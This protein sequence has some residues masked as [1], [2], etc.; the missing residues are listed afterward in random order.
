[1]VNLRRVA[2]AAYALVI[3]RFQREVPALAPKA[4]SKV[5]M[6]S[7]SF[8]VSPHTVYTFELGGPQT[9]DLA[10]NQPPC[11]GQDAHGPSGLVG[12]ESRLGFLA[13]FFTGFSMW[14]EHRPES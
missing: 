11:S 9:F 4:R 2:F 7:R 3:S 5:P 14:D 12:T 6:I 10:V 1:M 13:G 8:I